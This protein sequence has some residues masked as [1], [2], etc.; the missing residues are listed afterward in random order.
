MPELPWYTVEEDIQRLREIG[1]LEW[2][3][4]I[5]PVHPTREGPE[6]ITFSTTGRNKFVRGALHL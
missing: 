4:H 1:T 2:V 3:Y 6:E 5:S